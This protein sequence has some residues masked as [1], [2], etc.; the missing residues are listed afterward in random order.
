MTCKQFTSFKSK[1]YLSGSHDKNQL[2]N[3]KCR[4]SLLESPLGRQRVERRPAAV[5]IDDPAPVDEPVENDEPAPVDEPT[6]ADVPAPAEE[7]QP[8]VDVPS[9]FDTDSGLL[10]NHHC[11]YSMVVDSPNAKLTLKCQRVFETAAA[12]NTHKMHCA[13]RW[14]DDIAQ[15]M[16]AIWHVLEDAELDSSALVSLYKRRAEVDSC[17]VKKEES[18]KTV[19]KVDVFSL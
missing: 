19:S 14:K 9:T 10:V 4:L 17:T 8:V 11:P 6:Q 13:F 15:K 3:H 1:L 18:D 12:L 5:D 16:S 7:S 2:Y